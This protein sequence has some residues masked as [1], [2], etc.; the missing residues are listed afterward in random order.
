MGVPSATR[1]KLGWKKPLRLAALMAASSLAV[2]GCGSSGSSAS[3]ANPGGTVVQALGPLADINWYLPLRPVAYNSLYNDWAASLMFKHLLHVGSNGKINFQ[4][5]VAQSVTWN[6]SGT[7]YVVKLNPKWHWSNGQPVTA[8]DCLFTWSLIQAATA[9]NAP[10]PWPYAGEGSGGIPTLIR[11]VRAD[12]PR[13]FTVTLNTPV[14]QQWF[15]YNGLSDLSPLP[16]AAWDKYPGDPSRELAYLTANGNNASFFSHS[17]IDGPF[18]MAS[19]VEN[20]AWTFVPNPRY[21]GHKA[22]IDKFIL[23][24]ETTPSSE[25]SQLETGTLN[26]G[27]LPNSMYPIRGKLTGDRLTVQKA[28][29]FARVFLNYKNPS[30]GP[31]FRQLYVRQALQ[32]GIDQPHMISGLFHGLASPGTG[33]IPLSPPT[34]LDPRLR[35]PLYSFDPAQGKALLEQHGWHLSGGV[36]TNGKGQRLQFTAQYVAGSNTIASMAQMLQ[37]DWATEGIKV[38]LQPMPFSSMLELHHQPSKWEMQIGLDW[39]YGGTYPTGGGL[40]G[41]RGGYN[42]EG[43]SNRAMDSLIAATHAPHATAAAE[44]SALN[45]Y[46]VFAAVHLPTLWMPVGQGIEQSG[47]AV[48]TKDLQGSGHAINLFT[49][50]IHPQYWTFG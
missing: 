40:Y 9:P 4:R 8:Q 1:R 16:Q 6:A 29:D 24:Y 18:R 31:A 50:S 41:S 39:N 21:D 47:V 19:G 43:Y 14:D 22:S 15:E 10:P 13:Q 49:D 36:M 35:K 42:F 7:R 11:S 17:A 30:S 28:F 12:G 3:G 34:F 46:Q 20:Q 32:M 26:V 2:T 23:A 45:A 33:P 37:S 25:V 44:Q 5:S 48:V 38:S 27:Y